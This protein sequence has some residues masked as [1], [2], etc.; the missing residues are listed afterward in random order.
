MS[1]EPENLEPEFPIGP[2]RFGL[3]Y[4][5]DTPFDQQLVIM[6]KDTWVDF[7]TKQET[8]RVLL[9]KQDT[10]IKELL[11]ENAAKSAAITEATLRLDNIRA[12]RRDELRARIEKDIVLPGDEKFVVPSKRKN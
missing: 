10:R 8:M 7:G 12:S 5:I 4:V 2:A 3:V 1:T 11:A 9:K 6:S